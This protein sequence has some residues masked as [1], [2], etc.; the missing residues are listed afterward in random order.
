M[1][2]GATN[3]YYTIDPPSSL[4]AEEIEEAEYLPELY[5]GEYYG[6]YTV[7]YH[8][9]TGR[10]YM[11]YDLGKDLTKQFM[12][13]GA[14]TGFME[15]YGAMGS[16]NIVMTLDY[17]HIIQLADIDYQSLSGDAYVYGS[18]MQ[19]YA[20]NLADLNETDMARDAVEDLGLSTMMVNYY[21]SATSANAP[22]AQ[23]TMYSHSFTVTPTESTNAY[24]VA[25]SRYRLA[26]FDVT[27]KVYGYD[28]SGGENL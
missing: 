5:N 11:L 1:T 19:Y 26:Y 6:S 17:E 25:D 10:Y 7:E 22:L 21:Y 27:T 18:D 2:F 9:D 23:R 16:Y 4:T 20:G 12:I 3:L 13:N 8:A 14:T 28:P 15:I 24:T